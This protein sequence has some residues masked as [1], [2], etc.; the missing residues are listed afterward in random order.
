[1]SSTRCDV[2]YLTHDQSSK[3]SVSPTVDEVSV[4]TT[5]A[6]KGGQSRLQRLGKP[7]IGLE[8]T[9]DMTAA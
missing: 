4:A 9:A 7:D 1:M 6:R 5:W 2:S 3:F 8:S